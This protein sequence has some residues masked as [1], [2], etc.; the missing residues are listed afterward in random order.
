MKK[1]VLIV[2][3]VHECIFEL[4]K[5]KPV[6]LDYRP[7][8]S[9]EKVDEIIGHYHGLVTNSKLKVDRSFLDKATL[10]EFAVRAGS[11]M[12]VFDLQAAEEKGVKCTN[13]PEGNAD[14]VAEHALGFLLSLVN[15]ICKSNTEVRNWQWNREPNRGKEISEMT[16]GIIGYGNNGSAFARRLKS[17]GCRVLAYDKYKKG[18][19]EAGIEEV[20][21]QEIFDQVDILSLHIPLTDETK[22]WINFDFYE[23]FKHEIYFINCS[24][25]KIVSLSGLKKAFEKGLISGAA[26]DVLENEK[27][28][29]LTES[30]EKVIRSLFSENIIFTPHIA[31]WTQESKRKISEQLAVKINKYLLREA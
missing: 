15:N 14:A 18:F 19:G 30:Q 4:L 17:M 31:G 16:A 1:R 28:D 7:T 25:G 10:L 13:T 3:S 9:A 6:E 11:G 5:D 20:G 26:L 29:R 12:D 8:I 23:R 24:R 2:D 27:L 21:L 22:F